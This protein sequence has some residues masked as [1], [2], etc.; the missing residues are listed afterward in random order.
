MI[1]NKLILDIEFD[2]K[3]LDKLIKIINFFLVRRLESFWKCMWFAHI[4]KSF[5]D[6]T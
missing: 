5:V 2:L 6:A 1:D 3:Q 4:D